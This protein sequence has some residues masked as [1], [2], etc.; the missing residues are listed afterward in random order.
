MLQYNRNNRRW[1]YSDGKWYASVTE[2]VKNSLPTPHHLIE[3]YKT[4]TAEQSEKILT[5]SAKFGT[6]FHAYVEDLLRS[7]SLDVS[8]I[9][10]EKM[11]LFLASAAQFFYDYEVEPIT[12]E[13]R[14]KHD[15]TGRFPLNF[16]GTTDLIANT[17]KGLAIIDWKTGNIHDSHKYQMM[18][19]YLAWNQE[20]GKYVSGAPVPQFI[21]MRPKEWRSAKPTYEV[22][23][24][25][26]S[27]QDWDRLSA[28]C[29]I[30]EQDEPKPYKRFDNLTLGQAPSW[31]D[32]SP[33]A[34]DEEVF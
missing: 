17:S 34:Q 18:C 19:Y 33:E 12:I 3:W 28:M 20:D 6:D 1:Y 31:S 13:A 27:D 8:G 26:V 29:V 32:V 21:N 7:G 23:S 22:K 14:L 2:F 15:A 30:Y 11:L 9:E 16:A 10:D 25:A 4:N 24:W 5:E